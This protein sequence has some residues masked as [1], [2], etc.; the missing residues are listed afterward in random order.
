[1]T[2]TLGPTELYRVEIDVLSYE[3]PANSSD[4]H[5]RNWLRSEVR[6]QAGSYGGSESISILTWDLTSF[7]KQLEKLH[8]KLKGAATFDPLEGQIKLE[9]K[10]DGRGQISLIGHISNSHPHATT[11]T[12][13]LGFD[14]TYLADSIAQL[15]RVVAQFPAR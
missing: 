2:F 14:Q 10:G 1:M 15:R 9:L 11:L 5:D 12:F 4:R 8:D 3:Q 6:V 13:H 7:L